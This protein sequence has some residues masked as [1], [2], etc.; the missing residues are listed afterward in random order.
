MGLVLLHLV[1]VTTCPSKWYMH[2]LGGTLLAGRVMHGAA[3]FFVN[4]ANHTH[5][6][7]GVAL[8]GRAAGTILSYLS[9]ALSSGALL[10]HFSKQRAASLK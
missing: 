10:I 1:E 5:E 2:V 7:N 6:D 3:F 9:V 8:F 4:P